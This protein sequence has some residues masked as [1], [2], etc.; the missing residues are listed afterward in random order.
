MYHSQNPAL[1]IID[2]QQA[3]DHF[4]LLQRSHPN[5]E[6][7]LEQ[8]LAHWR[9]Q[10]W[11][12]IHV[13]HSSRHS[14]SPYHASSPWFEFKTE[15][16]PIEGECVITKRENCAFVD[17]GL[18]AFLRDNNICELVVGGV[19]LNHSVDATVRVA[20]ALKFRVILA[21]DASPASSIT[22][23]SQQVIGAE[24]VHQI[25]LANLNGE[26]AEIANLKELIR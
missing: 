10:G 15:V 22:L 14:D 21:E 23:D 7:S 3:I 24:Q 25:M 9:Q 5:A 8:L 2:V 19:L 17:T 6:Q 4:G 26:Y 16:T 11:P 18:E 13:R 12:V 1:V 20:R